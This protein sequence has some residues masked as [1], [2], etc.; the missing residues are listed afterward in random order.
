MQKNLKI[1]KNYKNKKI[2]LS[3]KSLKKQKAMIAAIYHK[4]PILTLCVMES[5]IFTRMQDKH[6]SSATQ[7]TNQHSVSTLHIE[8]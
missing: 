2:I 5:S 3:L 8:N 6:Q 1:V 7:T 4:N